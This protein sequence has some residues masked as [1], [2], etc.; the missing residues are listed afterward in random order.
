M[1]F[2]DSRDFAWKE[3]GCGGLVKVGVIAR[4]LFSVLKMK[5]GLA[6]RS[7]RVFGA[8]AVFRPACGLLLAVATM[9]TLAASPVRAALEVTGANNY[10]NDYAYYLQPYNYI[11]APSNTT[12]N[13]SASVNDSYSGLP[14]SPSMSNK[15][16]G[17]NTTDY[18]S[19]ILA[20]SF[21]KGYANADSNYPGYAANAAEGNGL[22]YFTLTQDS[23]ATL[24]LA[25]N[26]YTSAAVAAQGSYT[27]DLADAE[28][29]SVA[30]G[31]PVYTGSN[32]TA[33]YAS[34]GDGL[35]QIQLGDGSLSPSSSTTTQLYLPAGTYQMFAYTTVSAETQN[36]I[37]TH[38]GA[39]AEA[40]L[41][42]IQPVPEPASLA[43]WGLGALVC[44]A[45]TYRR[46]KNTMICRR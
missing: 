11:N 34:S 14:D 18:S 41:Y 29:D 36:P 7:R 13:G 2:A 8:W 33:L 6:M 27:S 32:W 46:R 23:T 30:T 37:S 16:S 26:A 15:G 40:Y 39:F 43:V 12:V 31:I 1:Y 20:Q 22:V 10:A 17:F 38:E 25:A 21:T 5:G 3:S 44:A 9:L 42:D 19:F 28:L 4:E 24:Y 45:A 35:S